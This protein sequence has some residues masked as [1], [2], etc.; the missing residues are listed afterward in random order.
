MGRLTL[1]AVVGAVLLAGCGS[2]GKSQPGLALHVSD[3]P[4]RISVVR[5]GKTVV[6]EDKSARLSYT[7]TSGA[8]HKLTKVTS[9]HGGVYEVATD[10]PG[11][12]ATVTVARTTHG[13]R[14]SMRL[15]PATGVQQ[16]YDAFTAQPDEHFLGGGENQSAVDL[17][18]Q[19]VS[20]KVSSECSYVAVPYF[21]SSAG[22]GLR[23]ASENVAA[24]AF[25]DS[26]GGGGCSFGP[27]PQCSFPALSELTEV[28]IKGARLDEDLYLGTVPQVLADYQQD[29]GEPV[30]PPPSELAL[31]KWRDQVK[32]PQDVIE[33]VTRLQQADIPIGW[34]LL[35]N[36]W[37]SCIGNLTFDPNLIPD[38][39]RMIRQVHAL[40]VKFMLWVSPKV[41]CGTGYTKSQLLGDPATQQEIDLSSPAVVAEF[42]T[43][44]RKVFALGV[45]GVKGDRGDEVDLE[46]KSESFQND[47]PLLYDKAV[48]AELPKDGAT[49]F[50]AGAMGS[51]SIARGIWAG[52]QN[53]DFD[54]LAKAIRSGETAAMSGFP[55]WGS[56]IGGYHS[57]GLTAEVFARWAQLGAVSPVFEVGGVGAN[58]TPWTLGSQAMAALRD[59]AVLHYELFPY[60]Y[61][62]LGRHEPVLRPLAYA[63]SGD[64]ASWAASNSLEF[65]VG[66]DLLAAPVAGPGE[67][68]SVYLPVGTWIDLYTGAPVT[69]GVAFIRPTPLTQ[70]PLYAKT[71][72]V[73]PFN[74]RTSSSWW[75]TNEQTHPGRAGWLATNGAT[76]DLRAQPHDVQIFVPAPARPSQVRIGDHAVAWTWND[77]PLPGVVVR[78]HGP[79]IQGE[80]SLSP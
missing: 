31:I 62:I 13:Y 33:D 57:E 46:A 20:V 2:S 66:P 18:G 63:Y 58:A 25:P 28:C 56:D 11:R 79:R 74:L 68:P 16:V 45:D 23:L 32:G 30:V 26:R 49:L 50:Q 55:T 72:A 40:G 52:D 53:G 59:A 3:N 80:I 76:L 41:I 34:V 42:K 10:E 24:L 44:L 21:A 27:E 19:I 77:G 5:D 6:A 1:A 51:E 35:D 61:G 47:Y 71:G 70:F 4:F 67:T 65:L 36:P 7:L 78:L 73:L 9:S 39:A 29:A 64:P 22:W 54:G 37:E 69:G 60:L 17:R 38:P 75:G 15:Q 14:L 43:R 8:T 48:I 12:T